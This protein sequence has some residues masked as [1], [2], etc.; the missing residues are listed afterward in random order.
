VKGSLSMK[1]SS[2]VD[3]IRELGHGSQNSDTDVTK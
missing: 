1:L 3:G 2:I